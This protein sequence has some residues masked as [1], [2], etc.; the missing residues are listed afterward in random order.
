MKPIHVMALVADFRVALDLGGVPA[1]YVLFRL[2]A[3]RGAAP[4]CLFCLMIIDC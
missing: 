3:A 2:E 1:I 4:L